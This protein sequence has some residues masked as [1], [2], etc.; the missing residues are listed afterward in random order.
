VDLIHRVEVELE[1]QILR[2][3]LTISERP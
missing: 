2:F 3:K 1:E